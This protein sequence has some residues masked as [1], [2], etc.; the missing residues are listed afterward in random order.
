MRDSIAHRGPDDA[1]VWESPSGMAILGSRRLSILD[2]SPGGHQPMENESGDLVIA[3]N[4]E[5]YNYV[6][7]TREL[8][9]HGCH[10]RSHSD[11]EVLLKSY[12][13]WGQ[14]CLSRLNGMFAF[15]IW[16]E[17][18]R[19][20]F[21]ARDRFGEKP[22]YF[23]HDS[24]Q[25]LFAFASEIK[26]LVA[27]GLI[28]PSPDQSAVYG[29]L[30]HRE[31]DAGADTL[32]DNVRSLPAAHALSYSCDLGS[33][34]IWRYWDL[35]PEREICLSSSPQYAEHFLELLSDSVRIRLRSDVPIGSSLSGGL[36][37]STIVG[38]IAKSESTAS[39]A[40]F[41]ARFRDPKFDEGKYIEEM[42]S[43]AKIRS[44]ITYPE[45]E[46][47]SEEIEALTWY[48]DAPFYSTSI[49]AQW[50][51]MRLAKEQGVTVLLDGQGGDEVLAGYHEYFSAYYLQLVKSFEW[52][53]A[54]SE[55]RQYM[56]DHGHGFLPQVLAGALP[57]GLRSTVKGWFSPRGLR[58]EF[59]KKWARPP[60]GAKRKYRNELQQSLYVTLT[61]T[62]LPQ[63]LRYADRN[64]MAFSREVRLPF[65]DHRL[66]EFL[67]A[68]PTDQKI[69]GSQTKVVLRNAISGIVPESIRLRKDKLGFAPP[70]ITWLRGPLRQW[71]QGLFESAQFRTREWWEPS[72]VDTVWGRFL[73]G[74]DRLHSAIWRWVSL[75]V[76]ARACLRAPSTTQNAGDSIAGMPA[77]SQHATSN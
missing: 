62:V 11:T 40:C 15:A 31:I 76:W 50:C 7:L 1:G 61:Q 37:S 68:I 42:T 47:I 74:E 69:R 21:A 46:K 4:G 19:E 53:K 9:Q 30:V 23:Y 34:K 33:P 28:S 32:F 27:G 57:V 12:Q 58:P 51:V 65:L 13:V 17:R 63:L 36:D 20:L 18:R 66:V 2:L 59:Q 10:F 43:W 64:S 35:D 49:Y 38:L 44:N 24:N 25:G 22:F 70:E 8:L 72:T 14:D 75:E 56:P 5:I 45:P 67:Y 71:I 41:S 3:F 39:Q 52:V 55:M 6:E 73:Q 77:S 60:A 26:A 54:F 48:Q 16:N 29:Y